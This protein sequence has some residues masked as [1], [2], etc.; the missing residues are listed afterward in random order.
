M[1]SDAFIAAAAAAVE[2][3]GKPTRLV[4]VGVVYRHAS[5]IDLRE[6]SH[7]R[8][9]PAEFGWELMC[10]NTAEST[11]AAKRLCAVCEPCK[12]GAPVF[13]VV[14]QRVE[15]TRSDDDDPGALEVRTVPFTSG[16]DVREY[17][18]RELPRV[19]ETASRCGNDTRHRLVRLSFLVDPT[20]ADVA[21]LRATVVGH[22]ACIET[23]R[24]L[25]V[26]CNTAR[27]LEDHASDRSWHTDPDRAT[28]TDQHMRR[29]IEQ[30]LADIDDDLSRSARNLLRAAAGNNTVAVIVAQEGKAWL[31]A[32]DEVFEFM[33]DGVSSITETYA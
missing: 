29:E 4:V 33:V 30:A 12:Q 3:R 5:N 1:E 21:Q 8:P 26:R 13:G 16:A 19:L 9:R 7:R 25:R 23:Q 17:L 11:T 6:T 27:A 2:R 28:A 14:C 10:S 22:R 24:R 32:R 20:A 31:E 18:S 15:T